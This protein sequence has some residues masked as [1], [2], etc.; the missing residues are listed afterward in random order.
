MDAY[1]LITR[2]ASE[3]VTEDEVRALAD[4]PEGKR[5]YVGYEPSGVLHIGHMLTANK[6]ID[7]QDAGFEVVVLLADVH[8]YL[9]G[10][11]TFEEIR[12]TAERMK[13]QFIAYGLD[14]SQTE[15]VLGS[16]FQLDESYVLDLHALELETTLSRAERAMAEI[17][18]G[19]SVTV[20]QAVYPIMQALDIVYL[21]V[22]LAIGGM[23][24]R[25]VHMLAR[26]TLPNI[27]EESP[28]CM[29][30][31]L[32]ADL[33]TGAGKMSS[34][35]G[36][37]IS[38]EDSTED[39]EEKVNS[40]FCPPTANPTE[41]GEE[42]ENPVLQIFEYHV[43]PRFERVVVERPDKYGGNLDY[44]DYES[45]E[46]D[47][48]SGELHPAD[49]KGALAGYLDELIAPGRKKIDA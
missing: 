22:D 1:D 8:A 45:L 23:E 27:G 32:I 48:E 28:T 11:G 18:S 7:L 46:A 35:K 41:D 19:D 29:H 20:A 34:S 14:E 37:T 42:R 31:P 17:K 26:D 2:N 21:D 6:L 43:F 9:N 10:K 47:L 4:D 15:F 5:A 3:V 16:E 49:A 24:Q 30:T 39:I 38:M 12:E 40:A 44:D 25:K 36:V 13:E 33:A